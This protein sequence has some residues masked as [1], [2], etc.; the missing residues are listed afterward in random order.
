MYVAWNF[1]YI[2]CNNICREKSLVEKEPTVPAGEGLLSR[3]ANRDQTSGTKGLT[4]CLGPLTT[5]D[6]MGSTW[7]AHSELGKPPFIPARIPARDRRI[8]AAA[9][10]W[11]FSLPRQRIHFPKKNYNIFFFF[12]FF[13]LISFFLI[14]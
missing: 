11:A 1:T 2:S 12:N 3:L 4:F 6:E 7:G 14:V 8:S 10:F 13:F 5:R 9:G